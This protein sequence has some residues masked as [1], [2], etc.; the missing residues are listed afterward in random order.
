[1]EKI[2]TQCSNCQAKFKLG[3]DK[4]GKKI[5]CPKCKGVFVVAELGGAPKQAAPKPASKPAAPKA[6]ASP[7]AEAPAAPPAE[8]QAPAP[9]AEKQVA[10]LKERPRPLQLKAS[11]ETQHTRF[12]PEK[13]EGVKAHISYNITG[14]GGGEWT[15]IV[16]NGTCNIHSGGDPSAK[17]QVRMTSKTY[18]KLA[19]GKL[20]GRVAFMLGKIKIKGDKAS[21]A[22][23][24]E[25]FKVPEI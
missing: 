9:A 3:C 11:F 2:I 12:I 8:E 5:R 25:C 16:D 15:L 4:V 23:V 1:V 14:D 7:A 17:S 20:D 19:Q 13:A 10:P 24:R 22:T 21:L 18:L 6:P